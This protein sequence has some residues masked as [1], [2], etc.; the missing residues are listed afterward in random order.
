MFETLLTP[1]NYSLTQIFQ[2]IENEV[3]LQ[4][5]KGWRNFQGS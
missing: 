5:F 3:Q 2:T 4:I 1:K